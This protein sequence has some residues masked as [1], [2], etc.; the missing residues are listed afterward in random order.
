MTSWKLPF[1]SDELSK[2]LL[3]N[4]KSFDVEVVV[5]AVVVVE[6]E[7]TVAEAFCL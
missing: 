3:L 5:G 6:C 7:A 1:Y 4:L 2:V